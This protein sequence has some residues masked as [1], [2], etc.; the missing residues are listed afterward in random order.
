MKWGAKNGHGGLQGKTYAL[1]T[2]A[3]NISR[4]LTVEEIT[5]YADKFIEFA[6]SRPDLIFLLTEVG[7]GL[8]GHSINDIA[9]LF[10]NAI[11]VQNI[12][13]PIKFWNKLLPN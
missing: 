12:H 11:N 5:P 8:A 13:M 4:T 10:K 3:K 6:K 1:P 2:V 7:C 9:P